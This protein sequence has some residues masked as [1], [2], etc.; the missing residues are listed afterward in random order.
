[1][2]W[3]AL[4]LVKAAAAILKNLFSIPKGK[5]PNKLASADEVN[6]FK[7][8]ILY[9]AFA[10]NSKWYEVAAPNAKIEARSMMYV[11]LS[12]DHRLIDGKDAVLFHFCIYDFLNSLMSDHSQVRVDQR[13]YH[14]L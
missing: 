1:M 3:V 6:L 7:R 5:K 8:T 11:A 10:K 13:L 9:A 12:Y 14:V 4:R 2:W